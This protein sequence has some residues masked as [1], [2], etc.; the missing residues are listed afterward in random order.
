MLSLLSFDLLRSLIR[1]H[2]ARAVGDAVAQDRS[3]MG[4]MRLFYFL[5]VFV[6]GLSTS[7]LP[8]YTQQLAEKAGLDRVVR[9]LGLHAPTSSPS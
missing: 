3:R 1:G 6:D 2:E 9:V 5:V 7:F 8:V 4:V